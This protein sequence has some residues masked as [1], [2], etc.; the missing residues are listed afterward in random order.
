MSLILDLMVELEAAEQ[1]EAKRV[2]GGSD[3]IDT[4][5]GASTLT[6]ET[7]TVL[8]QKLA[9]ETEQLNLI[10]TA[11]L[12]LTALSVHGYPDRKVFSVDPVITDELSAKQAA[13]KAFADELM[14]IVLGADAGTI[15]VTET[16][17]VVVNKTKK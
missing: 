9:H 13:M 8:Q 11:L 3:L 14:P 7:V 5:Q 17:P 4:A 15:S 1:L 2:V 6:P 10:K 12:A 16:K